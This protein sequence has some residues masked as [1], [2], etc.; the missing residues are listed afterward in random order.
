[1]EV[2]AKIAAWI[3]AGAPYGQPLIAG[4]VV[5]DRS[6]VTDE[7]R[8]WW[9]FAPL[10]KP[11]PPMVKNEAWV[12]NP[13]DRFILARCEAAGVMPNAAAARRVLIRRAYVG[14]AGL[15]P[16]P[17]KVEAFVADA[18]ADAWGKV[19]DELLAS[20]QYGERWARH[21]L[22]LARYAESH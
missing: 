20:P 19:V 6:K 16:E 4:K 21:W 15:P 5:K 2:T 17:E 3:D 18:S 11:M 14:I 22:D 10:Q 12:R 1:A 9:A 13:V 8:K 7:D